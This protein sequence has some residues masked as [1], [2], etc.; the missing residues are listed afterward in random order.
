M[1]VWTED[2][3]EGKSEQNYIIDKKNPT[4]TLSSVDATH[5]GGSQYVTNKDTATVVFSLGDTGGSTSPVQAECSI[6]NGAQWQ[7]CSSPYALPLQDATT[8]LK[9]RA[10][11]G[12][13]NISDEQTITIKKD[14]L[15]P[16]LNP[17][18]PAKIVAR[19]GT[20]LTLNDVTADD[21]VDG[22]GLAPEGVTYTSNPSLDATSP[23][24][25]NYTL[26]YNVKD[27]AGNMTTANREVEITDADVLSAEV[28][29]VTPELLDGKTQSSIAVVNQAKQEAETII[30]TPT[31][32]QEQI[33]DALTKL[34]DAIRNLQEEDT[35]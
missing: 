7:P 8:V 31:A 32:T 5:L 1:T 29:K 10:K 30:N 24:K 21:G 2:G 33:D 26:T 9:I 12:T 23:T 11:D 28:A 15:P 20:A 22:S 35:T 27:K 18:Q 13:G 6:N 3:F 17:T 16:A 14:T 34:Q 19:K 4:L 25:G